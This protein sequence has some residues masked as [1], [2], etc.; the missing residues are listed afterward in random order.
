M[1]TRY[2]LFQL[3]EKQKC[4]LQNDKVW[5]ILLNFSSWQKNKQNN[6]K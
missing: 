5:E 2:I 1:T 3:R 6:I 4:Q